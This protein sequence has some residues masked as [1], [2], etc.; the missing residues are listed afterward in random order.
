MA[1]PIPRRLLIHTVTL[2]SVTG[3]DM[4]GTETVTTTTINRV[5]LE[6]VD[7]TA[8]STYGEGKDDKYLMFWD[9]THS[10][11]A[12][13]NQLDKVTYDGVELTVREVF[14]ASDEKGLHHLE[15]YL[16]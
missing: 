5:R 12:T 15:I 11:T 7:R 8:L 2:S 10:T 1:R 14:R 4:Y 16:T 6:P 9:A 13:F 3:V